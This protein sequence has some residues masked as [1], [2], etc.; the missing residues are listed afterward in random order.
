MSLPKS[1]EASCDSRARIQLTLPRSVLISPL[2]AII[3]YG[4]ASSQLGNVFV[5]KRECTSASALSMPLVGQVGEVAAEL[6]RGQ[7]PLVDQRPRREARDHEVRAGRPLGDPPDHVEL[8]LEREQVAVE[9]GGRADEELAHHRGEQAGVRA[10]LALLDRDVAPAEHDLA[11]GRDGALEQL[12]ELVPAGCLLRQEAHGDAVAARRRQLEAGRRRAG[13]RPAAG[14]GCPLRRRS[15][16]PRRPPRGA[17]GSRARAA[18]ARSPRGCA[19][20]SS[21]ATNATPQASCSNAGS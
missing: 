19:S 13:R 14:R 4:C 21:R 7:H 8:A 9:L 2:C 16:R 5:E 10:R 6:R 12:L 3:R 11:L 15:R 1:S 20:P 17:R 18:P